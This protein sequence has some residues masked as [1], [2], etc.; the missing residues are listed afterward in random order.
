MEERPP[1]I[2]AL[3]EIKKVNIK[4]CTINAGCCWREWIFLLL[5]DPDAHSCWLEEMEGPSERGWLLMDGFSAWGCWMPWSRKGT[6]SRGS[7]Q[8]TRCFEPSVTLQWKCARWSQEA[9]CWMR[10]GCSL[11]W[12]RER[13]ILWRKTKTTKSL[14][15]CF[16]CYR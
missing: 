10:I 4:Q 3:V 9:W 5:S 15:D 6:C 14:P 16:I 11:A 2:K 13:G 8:S 7:P 12:E 1:C